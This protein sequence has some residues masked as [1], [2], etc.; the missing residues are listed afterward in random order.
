MVPVPVGVVSLYADVLT[1]YRYGVVPGG[2]YRTYSTMTAPAVL[3][4]LILAPRLDLFSFLLTETREGVH[5]KSRNDL[6]FHSGIL[7]ILNHCACSHLSV[8]RVHEGLIQRDL[9]LFNE[10]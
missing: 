10:I 3:T 4:L 1:Y 2:T 6:A 9:V 5:P 8:H 7:G